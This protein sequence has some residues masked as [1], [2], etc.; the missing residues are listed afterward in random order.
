MTITAT[1]DWTTFKTA[2][3]QWLSTYAAL[4]LA[5]PLTVIWARQAEPRPAKP[6]VSVLFLSRGKPLGLDEQRP[7]YNALSE[8]IERVQTGPRIVTLQIEA[9]SD[10]AKDASTLE[11]GDMLQ[12]AMLALATEPVKDLLRTAM[13]GVLDHT[14]PQNMDEQLGQRW[15]R[16]AVCEVTL[17]YSG[18]T[19][20]D[21]DGGSGDWIE[22]ADAPT[23]ENGNADYGV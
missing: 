5:A 22:T 11:A 9:Y 8:L 2:V 6:Y 1:T 21:G 18:E 12:N 13:I 17:L 16:R 20:D 3:L 7:Q 10:E 14:D 23:E 19:F 4:G 15:E